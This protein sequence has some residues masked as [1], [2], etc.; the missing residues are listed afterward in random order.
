[1]INIKKL[2]L[3]KRMATNKRYSLYIKTMQTFV[4]M[5]MAVVIVWIIYPAFKIHMAGGVAEATIVSREVLP[6]PIDRGE[7]LISGKLEY[8]DQR[9]HLQSAP[10]SEGA[11]ETDCDSDFVDSYKNNAHLC[12]PIGWKVTIFYDP[13]EPKI[14]IFDKIFPLSGGFFITIVM[15]AMVFNIWRFN[16]KKYLRKYE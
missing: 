16:P 1:L 8:K 3:A 6:H 9:G 14:I 5:P 7:I 10:F 15:I 2:E 11:M 4:L 13:A 12:Y